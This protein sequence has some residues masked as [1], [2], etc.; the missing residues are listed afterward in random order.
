MR[1]GMSIV[2]QLLLVLVVAPLLPMLIS[3]R[4]DWWEAWAF[5][6]ILFLGFAL[7]RALAER[8]HPGLLAERAGS[9]GREDAKPWD[10]VL[11]PALALGGL[12]V[13]LVAGLE[14]RLGWTPEPFSLPVKIAAMAVLVLA[15]AF[16]SWAMV[17]NAFF[18][19]VVRLQTDRGQTVCSSGP[20]RWVR[21]PGYAGGL[22]S[23][24]AMPLILDTAWAFLLV[25][26][27][28]A[29]TIVRT[30]LEDRTLQEELPG[31]RDYARRVRYRLLPG[32]W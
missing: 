28:L 2:L 7:S 13:P 18:S 26:P 8:R 17:E 29:V 19:G 15:Y 27:L 25:V 10:K 6:L 22:W 21:H 12:G 23:Y 16:A 4:W 32:I 20:Y 30:R 9:L 5:A 31:Y 3:W 1:R 11:A 24:L 14:E